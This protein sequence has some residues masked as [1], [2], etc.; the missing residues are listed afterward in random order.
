MAI[1]LDSQSYSDYCNPENEISKVLLIGAGGVGAVVA[2]SLDYNQKCSVSLVVRRDYPVVSK[3]GYQFDSIDYG[4][5][6]NWKPRDGSIFANISDAIKDKPY[7][8]ILISTK[9]L[10][11]ITK[12]E[13]IIEPLVIEKKTTIIL[14]QNGFGNEVPFFE[15]YP[16]NIILSGVTLIGSHNDNGK[17][18]QIQKDRTYVSYFNNKHIS[19]KIQEKKTLDF[20]SIYQNSTNQIIYQPDAQYHRYRKLVY[21][22]TLNTTC[23]ITGVDVGRIDAFGGLQTIIV[24]AM[25]EI[26][27][28]AKADGVN[29]PDEIITDLIHSDDG[30]YF[31]PSMLID[32]KKGNPMELEV[33]LGNVLKKA[34]LFN[35]DCPKLSML[36]SLL[37]IIQF[38]LKEKKGLI[39]ALPKDRPINP[40]TVYH[41]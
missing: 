23:A 13:N 38:R 33:I 7:D 1:D 28:I 5:I 31:E 11:D 34:K 36:Y 2:Y 9:N 29:L 4:K 30:D 14:F 32:V 8:Y 20:I 15:K 27:S 17:I 10:P 21:N 19:T 22:A 25:K 41:L 39:P 3:E 40:D 18:H 37:S 24:P 35:I 16:N 12:F 26:I 6:S